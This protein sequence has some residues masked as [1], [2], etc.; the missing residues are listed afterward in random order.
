MHRILLS[1]I[2]MLIS[3]VLCAEVN[4]GNQVRF[5]L[6]SAQEYSLDLRLSNE[7][8]RV[9][10]TALFTVNADSLKTLDYYSFFV[11]QD[12]HIEQ[13]FVNSRLLSPFITS[14]LQAEH[15]V[16]SLPVPALLD[17]TSAMVCYSL[18]KAD[19]AAADSVHF[20]VSFWIPL[21]EWQPDVSNAVMAGFLTDHYWFPRNIVFPSKVNIKLQ[22][23][24]LYKLEL[25][26][27]CLTTEN[28]GI[29]THRGCFQDGPGKSSFLKIIKTLN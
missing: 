6:I 9:Y 22:S 28:K 14:N 4:K 23:S 21:P 25:D 15:F 7:M 27:P 13:M 26:N 11:N 5:G 17:S 12:V 8:Q 18:K 3:L 29:R 20:K 1:I 10:I 24:Y 2:L 16:P 19:L